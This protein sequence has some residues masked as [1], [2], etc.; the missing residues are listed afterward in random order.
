M[1][2]ETQQKYLATLSIL[3][4]DDS[5]SFLAGLG[6]LIAP[7]V[8]KFD[9]FTRGKEAVE[10][11]CESKP[12]IIISDLEMP[13]FSGFDVI[14]AVRENPMFNDVP[15][16]VLT[17]KEDSEIMVK[18]INFGADAFVVK[19]SVRE[20]LLPQLLALARIKSVYKGVTRGK[21]L[22]AVQ[23]LIGTYKHEFGNALAAIDG[24]IRKIERD[25]PATKEHE[26][27]GSLHKWIERMV[28]TLK[29]L[30]GLRRYEEQSYIGSSQ[31]I[32][33]E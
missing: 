5:R 2:S 24:K 30:D 8:A 12:D 21:Q 28:D 18:A 4:V 32:K 33:T 1:S 15:I 7:H 31:M 6:A 11:I 25:F 17:G 27:V 23:A 9:T 26:P 19:S 20:S 16:L 22:E 10:Y 14:K 13:E 29:K 3:V